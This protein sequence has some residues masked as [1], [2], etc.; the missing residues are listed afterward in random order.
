MSAPALKENHDSAGAPLARSRPS[1]ASVCASGMSA[2]SRFGAFCAAIVF[3]SHSL[4]AALD[5]GFGNA[6]RSLIEFPGIAPN[7]R[8]WAAA[9]ALHPD[10][11]IIATGAV[12][13][14]GTVRLL[15]DGTLDPSFNQSG[16]RISWFPLAS[17]SGASLAVVQ[18]DGKTII[19]GS[20][21]AVIGVGTGN[22]S[23][24]SIYLMRFN[25]D[26]SDDASFG[27]DGAIKSV[28]KGFPIYG[29]GAPAGVLI[30]SNGKIV[31]ATNRYM[32]RHN[33][34]GSIDPSFAHGAFPSG[35]TASG[36]ASQADGRLVV[37]GLR[38]LSTGNTEVGFIR[39]SADGAQEVFAMQNTVNYRMRSAAGAVQPD[40]KVLVVG[41]ATSRSHVARYLP[42]GA[43]DTSFGNG[44]VQSA[45]GPF[46]RAVLV[47][48][49]GKILLQSFIEIRRLLPDGTPDMTF[50]VRGGFGISS[51][52]SDDRGGMV[53]Q[54]DGRIVVGGRNLSTGKMLVA[55]V[56]PNQAPILELDPPTLNFG[57]Q[58]VNIPIAITLH[59]TNVQPTAVRV[60]GISAPTGYGTSHDCDMLAPGASCTLVVSFTPTELS[61][62]SRLVVA[63]SK[64]EV[65]I[66][67]SGFG[68]RDLVSYFY[69]SILRR[70]ADGAGASYWAQKL[71]A[72]SQLGVNSNEAWYG[73]ASEFFAGTEYAA[74]NR[75]DTEFLRDLY[76]T[77]FGRDMDEAGR[78]YWSGQMGSG[79][80]RDAV[81]V[82]FML[83]A[84]F[85]DF[86]TL[87][88]GFNQVSSPSAQTVLDFYR[89]I[90]AR[91]PDLLGYNHW[92]A[93]FRGAICFGASATESAAE[94]ISSAFVVSPEYAGRNRTN[95]QFVSD[96]YNAFMRRGGDL[97]GLRFWVG[98]LDSGTRTRDEVRRQFTAS[99]EF[100]ARVSAMV[101]QGCP[102]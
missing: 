84:E 23:L 38:Q 75:S 52:N 46:W 4:A 80:P 79:L 24:E 34:D 72:L 101:A 92:L 81:L 26:G 58:L 33:V 44:G 2:R 15:P 27:G 31:A 50:G 8:S 91:I 25:A 51:G 41:G 47:Q 93:Q 77:F 14:A 3:S 45:T 60:T 69:R 59:V 64:G 100:T 11:R 6:G 86:L 56:D 78:A 28:M 10:G 63:T 17:P 35:F 65:E 16:T 57:S 20:Y 54:P 30:Q 89:G 9:L 29:S 99:P 85:R 82:N 98:Q 71:S 96:M 73:M 49:D 76:R 74:F 67:S 7:A 53:L 55:R 94:A 22:P 68:E 32:A 36:I 5:P 70:E 66:A 18:P 40:G 43:L 37:F 61:Q 48:P 1:H 102:R 83:S 90:L 88:Y 13:N 19:G 42:S 12:S 97:E 87:V 39:F 21:T 62:G 95:G